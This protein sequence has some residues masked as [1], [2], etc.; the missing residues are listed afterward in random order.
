MV[1]GSIQLAGN[2]LMLAYCMFN[3]MVAVPQLKQLQAARGGNEAEQAGFMIGA[4]VSLVGMPVLTLVATV[5]SI[6]MIRRQGYGMAIAGAIF[7]MIGC[8]CIFFPVGLWSLIVLCMADY[9]RQFK[10]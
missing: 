10:T 8:A 9:K 3:T 4:V 2:L 7:S 6:C 1:P 5:G